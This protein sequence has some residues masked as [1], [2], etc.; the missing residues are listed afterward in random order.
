MKNPIVISTFEALIDQEDNYA[1]LDDIFYSVIE[2]YLRVRAFSFAKDITEKYKS[3][4]KLEK[5]KGSLRKNIKHP[6]K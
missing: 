5:A 6:E 1:E 3:K 2:L 4:V